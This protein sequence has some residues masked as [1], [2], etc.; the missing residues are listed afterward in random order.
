MAVWKQVVLVLVLIVAAVV[1]WG[2]FDPTARERLLSYGVPA[3]VLPEVAFLARS[4]AADADGGDANR[5]GAAQ[6][7]QASG[8]PGGGQRGGGGPGGP[9]TVVTMPAKLAT[10]NDRVTA[11][12]TGDAS[13]SITIVPRSAGMVETVEFSSGERVEAGAVLVRLDDDAERIAL[14][15]AELTVADARAKVERYNRLANSSAISSVD[16]DAARTELA[17][18]E[19]RVRQAS[20]DLDRRRVVA[21]FSGT[22]GL[23]DV[24]PGD[25]VSATTEIATLDD[26]STLRV[27]FRV[28]ESVAA[29]VQ[30]DQPVSATT[31][32]RPGELFE[33]HVSALASRIEID[34]RTLV[35][36]ARIDNEKDLLRP[37]MSFLVEL[38]FPGDE[39]MAVPALSVQWDRDGSFVWRVTDGKAERVGVEIVERNAETVLVNGPLA[40]GD[41]VV[42]EGVQRLR[43]GSSVALAG[44]TPPSADPAAPRG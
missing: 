10:T 5:G 19:L 13:R 29:K 37:G 40:L 39:H 3:I 2:A 4:D 25:M 38:R 1:G 34:S 35:V 23:T 24:G 21:P 7:R 30:L 28:P 17:A 8:G 14:E 36:Q 11:I 15:Q 18:S 16:R 12:G 42:I 44:E 26:R 31:P 41:I 43:P 22:V 33:G 6:G 9:V 27:E 20:L 32:A